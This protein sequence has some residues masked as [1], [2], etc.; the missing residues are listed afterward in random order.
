[1]YVLDGRNPFTMYM[2]MRSPGYTLNMSYNFVSH[3]K[4]KEREKKDIVTQ[5]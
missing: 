3:A 1:M 5:A 4:K 2:Y